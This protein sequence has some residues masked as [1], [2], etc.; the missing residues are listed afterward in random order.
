MM[1]G[2]TRTMP[3]VFLPKGKEVTCE[4]VFPIGA[5]IEGDRKNLLEIVE[6]IDHTV[7]EEYNKFTY[8]TVFDED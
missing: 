4:V 1:Q 3:F 5:M 6:E 2:E 8:M 7:S